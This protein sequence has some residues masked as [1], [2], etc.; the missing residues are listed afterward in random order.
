MPT[1]TYHPNDPN[2]TAYKWTEVVSGNQENKSPDDRGKTPSDIISEG[3]EMTG[4][5]K[6]MVSTD[7]ENYV[8]AKATAPTSST[9]RG[10]I[11]SK[12][13]IT[14][15]EASVT[16]LEQLARAAHINVG[17]WVY[18][19]LWDHENLTWID[20]SDAIFGATKDT[21]ES[22][23]SS[24]IPDVIDADVIY[25]LTWDYTG[26]YQSGGGCLAEGTKIIMWDGSLKRIENIVKGDE[27]R[28]WLPN[29]FV[30]STVVGLS[31]HELKER[32]MVILKGKRFRVVGTPDHPF[33]T[34]YGVDLAARIN[35]EHQKLLKMPR[36]GTVNLETIDE[37]IFQ[38]VTTRCFDIK[39][40]PTENY[41]TADNILVHNRMGKMWA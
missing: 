37:R 30:K 39:V 23:K 29:R 10:A 25:F 6:N 26:K 20:M 19:Y 17:G 32:D 16:L 8:E 38:K 7:D 40:D 14:E 34:D 13:T 15:A 5:E 21:H 31:A 4:T 36:D 11:M 9:A 12:F 41:F 2:C 33:Y 28:G 1:S 22:S 35:K 24:N 18:F 27:I 3:T